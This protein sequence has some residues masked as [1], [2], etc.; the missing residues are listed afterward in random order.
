[1]VIDTKC[2]ILLNTTCGVDSWRCLFLLR[3]FVVEGI[4]AVW[5]LAQGVGDIAGSYYLNHLFIC[6]CFGRFG[7]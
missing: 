6:E 2:L 3:I 7:Q 1:L 4:E 5:N